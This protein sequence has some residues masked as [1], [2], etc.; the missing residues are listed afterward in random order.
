[1]GME[2]RVR[3]SKEKMNEKSDKKYKNISRPRLL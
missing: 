1:M 2:S 3:K